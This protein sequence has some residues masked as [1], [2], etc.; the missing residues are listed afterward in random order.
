MR[1]DRVMSRW[2]GQQCSRARAE[3]QPEERDD[4]EAI[5]RAGAVRGRGARA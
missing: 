2:A 3:R 5:M 1:P 4:W